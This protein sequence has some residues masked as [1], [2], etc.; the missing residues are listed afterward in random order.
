[1]NC[2]SDTFILS[3]GVK[4]PC[5]GF[6]TWQTPNGDVAANSVAAAIE[7]GYRH[8]DTAAVYKNEEGVGEGIRQSGIDRKE[9]FVTTK[10]WNTERD[11]EKALRAFDDSLFR[12]GLDYVDL[13]LIHWPANKKQF[14]NCDEIN[15]DTWRAMEAIYES[16]RAKAIGISNFLVHHLE[17]LLV[18]A[19]VKPAVNQIEF[20]PGYLQEKTV[21][22]CKENNIIVEGYSPLGT[23][24]LLGNKK[25]I[26]I[27]SGYGKSPAQICI[28]FV[29]QKGVIP[30]PKSVTPDRIKEN[31][32]IFDFEISDED[33]RAIEG[34]KAFSRVGSDPDK[35]TF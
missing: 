29:L 34:I 25:L 7:V 2:L 3:N 8:I 27:A 4:I 20:H 24:K 15:A 13:Y 31:A 16:G 28:R 30:L 18:S 11:Y 32:N 19:N 9:L 26:K 23:G 6:G 12:L 10:L 35:I 22:F 33:M 5:V 17:K 1:M 21:S 14:K